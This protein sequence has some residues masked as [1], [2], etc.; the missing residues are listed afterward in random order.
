MEKSDIKTVVFDLGNVLLLFDY[1]IIINN[2]NKINSGLGEKFEKLYEENYHIHEAFEK[3]EM[4]VNEFTRTMLEWLDYKVDT[5]KFCKIF[6]GM[7]TANEELMALL[8]LIKQKFKLVLL[9]NTNYIHQK[10]GWGK[11]DFLKH[12]DKLILS[13][14]A[15]S[16]K[17]EEKIYRVVED[18]TGEP[19]ESHFFTDDISEYVKAANYI[20]WDAVQFVSNDLLISDLKKRKII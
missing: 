7:F 16:R 5:E 8:P 19:S 15:G 14:E 1:K 3:G 9:S 12:F 20:G 2:F 17:P 13:H 10:Y 18:Y 11:Y 6:S 4:S